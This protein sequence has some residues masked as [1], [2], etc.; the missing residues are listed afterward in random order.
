MSLEVTSR[1]AVALAEEIATQGGH[2]K[3]VQGL[4]LQMGRRVFGTI[5][6]H[7]HHSQRRR[8]KRR[9]KSLP[10]RWVMTERDLREVERLWTR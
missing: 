4:L 2:L 7:K 1:L 8:F 10:A 3:F 9:V 5:S 6:A